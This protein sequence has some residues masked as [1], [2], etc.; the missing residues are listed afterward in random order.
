MEQQ[1]E[2]GR[3]TKLRYLDF[4]QVAAAQAAVYLAGLYGLA[5][6]HAGPL[7]PG[8]DAVESTVKGVVGPVYAR[9]GGLPLDVLAFVDR[10]V[11]RVARPVTDPPLLLLLL[12]WPGS[13]TSTAAWFCASLSAAVSR[14][15]NLAGGRTHSRRVEHGAVVLRP[16]GRFWSPSRYFPPLCM[17]A[18][19]GP[20][21]AVCGS[22]SQLSCGPNTR[23]PTWVGWVCGGDF[24]SSFVLARGIRPCLLPS[25]LWQIP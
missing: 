12:R 19:A 16:F 10:K 2:P 18:M 6:D 3:A 15:T 14:D 23:G 9:F 8:V 7:R 20:T 25:V 21:R 22:Q 5:K 4:V 11:S 13:R 24:S 17:I 1:Q